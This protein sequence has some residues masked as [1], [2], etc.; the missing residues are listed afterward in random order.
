[1]EL[2]EREHRC[3]PQ[4]RREGEEGGSAGGWEGEW[5]NERESG[6]IEESPSCHLHHLNTHWKETI[7]DRILH[8][9]QTNTDE[10]YT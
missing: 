1:M 8:F 7:F 5:G 10:M 3:P 2:R 9:T 6:K 4:T